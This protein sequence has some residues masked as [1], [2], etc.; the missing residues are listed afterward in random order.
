MMTDYHM[1]FEYGTY[2]ENWVKLF[3]QEA[4]KKGL[5]EI[6]ISEHTHGFKEFKDLYYEELILDDSE[7]GQFQ[8]KWLDNSKSKFVHTLDEYRDFINYLKSKGYPVKFGL[9][10]CN[11]QNQEK[12]QEILS[13]YEWDYLI[14][15][16]HFIRG[17]GFD[18]SAL[19]HK[20]NEESLENIWKDYADEI[21]NVAN[22]GFYDILG[23]PFNLRLFKNI[24]DKNDVD[25]LLEKTA[26]LLK[27]NNMVADVNTGTLHR[28]PIKEITPYPDFMEYIKKYDIPIIFSSDAHQPEHVGMKI[29]E[30][31]E[32]VKKYG[33]NEIVTFDKRKRVMENIG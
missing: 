1:H 17:W 6:G 3:F 33:I 5:N 11:F 18:F 20:F 12:V 7:V 29:E 9:E 2:D 4:Q 30:A 31:V 28:Y 21:A 19:K 14:V 22:T 23:H 10:V 16:I 32:Y 27:K 8:R 25:E 26:K 24:P 15:S 13:K